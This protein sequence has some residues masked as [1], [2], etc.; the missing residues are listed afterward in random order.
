CWTAGPAAERMCVGF[1]GIDV[2]SHLI[3][4]KARDGHL[5]QR[6]TRPRVGLPLGGSRKDFWRGQTIGVETVQIVPAFPQSRHSGSTSPPVSFMWSPGDCVEHEIE[7]PASWAQV[8][9]AYHL[10]GC[11]EQVGE[12]F[13]PLAVERGYRVLRHQDGLARNRGDHA[14]LDFRK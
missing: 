5:V 6:E 12:I 11:A 9:R 10:I 7:I 3:P 1:A 14:R 4:L 8:E 13:L 2:V